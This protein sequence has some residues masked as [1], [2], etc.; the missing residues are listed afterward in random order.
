MSI[1]TRIYGGGAIA[2]GGE[3]V[4][5][6]LQAAGYDTVIMWSVHVSGTDHTSGKGVQY[7]K[8][9]LILNDSRIVSQGVYSEQDPM[10]L[11]ANLAKLRQGGKVQILFSV[12]SGGTSDWSNIQT[13]MGGSVPGPTNILYKNFKALKDAMEAVGGGDIDGIDFDNEDNIASGVMVDFGQM[14]AD[15]GYRQVTLCPYSIADKE[16]PTNNIWIDTLEQL[17]TKVGAGFVS[18]IHLQCYSG[19]SSNATDGFV[20]NWVNLINAA[21]GRGFDGAGLMIPGLSTSQNS[22]DSKWWNTHTTPASPGACVK[23]EAGVAQCANSD[24]SG[25]LKTVSNTKP[26]EAMQTAQGDGAVTFF[27]YCKQGLQIGSHV[28]SANDALFFTG[29]PSWGSAPQCDGYYLGCDCSGSLNYVGVSSSGCPS[30]LQSQFQAWKAY[31]HGSSCPGGGFIW[32]YDSVMTCLTSSCCGG[33]TSD[34]VGDA[35][36]FRAAITSGLS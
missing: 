24:W 10:N 32:L 20:A 33:S 36:A 18:A 16:D 22:F 9:D 3:P 6:D 25:Y 19:G 26:D 13:L 14:L 1:S 27:F 31:E 2:F 29:A 34:P 21:M 4:I 15:I 28:F 12:G 7:Y 8:G 5:A 11:P 35:T 23:Q 30:A 17:D